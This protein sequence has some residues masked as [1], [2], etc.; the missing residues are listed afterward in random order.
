MNRTF[1]IMV[2]LAVSLPLMLFGG[3]IYYKVDRSP[4]SDS[5]AFKV[6]DLLTLNINESATSSNT[7]S[8]ED[9]KEDA[10][11]FELKKM[12]FPH[13]NLNKGFD[14]TA[15]TGDEPGVELGSKY[16]FKSDGSRISNHSFTT[17]MQVQIV[18]VLGSGVFFVRGSKEININGKKKEIFVS[19]KVRENDI[20]I[21]DEATKLYNSIETYNLA[22]AVIEIDD[23]IQTKD[24]QPGWF[25]NILK[26]VFY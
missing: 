19:G 18:E 20:K 8:V 11:A 21:Y 17:K 26:S 22:D 16:E 1:I 15:S 6:G 7:S 23:E 12:F 14:D 9:S 3:G 5:R 2:G 4:F 24:G 10:Q 13:F 25:S